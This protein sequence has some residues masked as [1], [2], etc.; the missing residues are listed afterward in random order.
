MAVEVWYLCKMPNIKRMFD[1]LLSVL[2][3]EYIDVV[4][5]NK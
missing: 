2:G 1:R 4:P 3:K 5:E